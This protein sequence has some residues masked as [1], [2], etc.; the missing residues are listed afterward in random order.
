MLQIEIGDRGGSGGEHSDRRTDPTAQQYRREY[1]EK[2][3]HNPG[4]GG[5]GETF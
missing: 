5:G 1:V 4:N 2:D 3:Y